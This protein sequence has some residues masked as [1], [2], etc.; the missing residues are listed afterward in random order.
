M[1]AMRQ[2]TGSPHCLIA[3][4]VSLPDPQAHGP[5]STIGSWPWHRGITRIRRT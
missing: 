2:W 5:R 1:A 3:R 4:I